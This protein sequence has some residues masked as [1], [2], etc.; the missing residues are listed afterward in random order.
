MVR[1]GSIS[2]HRSAEHT[3]R[4]AIPDIRASEHQLGDG[5][6]GFHIALG[7]LMGYTVFLRELWDHAVVRAYL[8]G[9]VAINNGGSVVCVHHSSTKATK[10]QFKGHV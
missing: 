9:V 3:A 2:G 1:G 10:A 6:F 5:S 4:D 8:F 7:G